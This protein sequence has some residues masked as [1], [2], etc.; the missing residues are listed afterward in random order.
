MCL[1]TKVIQH[2]S[3]AYTSAEQAAG[4]SF[5]RRTEFCEDLWTNRGRPC[6]TNGR[7]EQAIEV[8]QISCR[9]RILKSTTGQILDVPVPEM[10][11]QLVEAPATFSQDR[12]QHRTVERIVDV[13]VPGG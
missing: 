12:I 10:A 2:G 9:S 1:L 13:P 3:G 7:G 4:K 5:C 11:Q 8:S 6:S